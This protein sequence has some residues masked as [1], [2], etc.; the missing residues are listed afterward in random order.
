MRQNYITSSQPIT[1]EQFQTLKKL[2]I[3]TLIALDGV[4]PLTPE[5]EAA[6]LT[7]LHIPVS[8]NNAHERAGQVISAVKTVEGPVYLHCH[9]GRPR[10][11]VLAALVCRTL[12]GWDA[13]QTAAW[14][15]Q[16]EVAESY[17]GLAASVEQFEPPTGESR[18]RR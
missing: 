18:S 10:T 8:F 2:G 1:G 4:R 9:Y 5:A 14:L 6:G 16:A 13:D 11:P 7:C 3:K 15:E 17:D 12:H